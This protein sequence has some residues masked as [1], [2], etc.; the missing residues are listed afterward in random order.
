MSLLTESDVKVK[1]GLFFGAE[2]YYLRLYYNF[3]LFRVRLYKIDTL[4]FIPLLENRI[5]RQFHTVDHV[6]KAVSKFESNYARKIPRDSDLIPIGNTKYQICQKQCVQSDKS[7]D[8][9]G[10]NRKVPF[11]FYHVVEFIEG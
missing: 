7:S 4:I 1:F 11:Y 9:R 2:T 5:L 3:H 6:V 10:L 8:T